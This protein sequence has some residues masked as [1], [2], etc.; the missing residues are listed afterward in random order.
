MSLKQYIKEEPAFASVILGLSLV[1]LLGVLD[2]TAGP[3][4]SLDFFFLIPV[5]ITVWFAGRS[6]GLLMA[7]FGA[8]T[9]FAADTASSPGTLT[10]AIPYWNAIM[11]LGF[12][13]AGAWILP[14][15]KNEWEQEKQS[16]RTDYLTKTANK[17][18]FETA[19]QGELDRAQ[20]YQRPFSVVYLDIDKFKFVND[21]YGHN[22]GDTLLRVTAETIQSKIR[23]SDLVAR[24][25][26]DEFALLLPETQSEPAQIVVKRIQKFLLDAA[27]KNEWP[28]TFSFGVATFLR[29]PES[30]D[31]MVKKADVLMY[32]AKT[33]GG[34]T[35]RH[36]V[37][38][39]VEVS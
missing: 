7:F 19:A 18:T 17:R 33:A 8:V 36:D 9:W 11:K 31:E 15:L 27:Q 34:N 37:V 30:V 35:V 28:V 22:A 12:L 29:A 1:A 20:R 13:M 14:A 16:A 23:A 4:I 6:A 26:G 39:P 21:R 25:G 3:H 38:G 24:V 32:A 2:Y 10:S 5:A